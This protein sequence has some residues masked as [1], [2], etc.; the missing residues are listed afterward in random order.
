LLLNGHR[1][2][3]AQ[4]NDR[5]SFRGRSKYSRDPNDDGQPERWYTPEEYVR[6]YHLSLEDAQNIERGID[7]GSLYAP[8]FYDG[9]P[10]IRRDFVTIWNMPIRPGSFAAGDGRWPMETQFLYDRFLHYVSIVVILMSTTM[11]QRKV[12]QSADDRINKA[13]EYAVHRTITID[14]ARN[15]VATFLGHFT[16]ILPDGPADLVRHYPGENPFEQK[17]HSAATPPTPFTDLSRSLVLEDVKKEAY[18][19][20]SNRRKRL[21]LAK[22]GRDAYMNS[23]IPFFYAGHPMSQLP[24]LLPPGYLRMGPLPDHATLRAQFKPHKKTEIRYSDEMAPEFYVIWCLENRWDPRTEEDLPK[25]LSLVELLEYM[26]LIFGPD[27]DDR[28]IRRM[29]YMWARRSARVN[30]LEQAVASLDE[31][32]FWNFKDQTESQI[33]A[34][35]MRSLWVKE[36]NPF[37]RLSFAS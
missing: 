33:I 18:A 6:R 31:L 25:K 13:L 30:W 35:A 8:T 1:T 34:Q 4:R 9:R 14:E 17:L 29:N 22:R 27:D 5:A 3:L 21:E 11:E 7:E 37:G 16:A 26:P 12:L 19:R 20:I 15:I 2:Q 23:G 24:T 36:Y 28:E 32:D 10:Y